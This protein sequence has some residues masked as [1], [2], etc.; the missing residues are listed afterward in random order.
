MGVQIIYCQHHSSNATPGNNF[1]ISCHDVQLL[2]TLGTTHK[3]SHKKLRTS[4]CPPVLC[5]SYWSMLQLCGM[6]LLNWLRRDWYWCPTFV[7]VSWTHRFDLA[8]L[9]ALVAPYLSLC[10]VSGVTAPFHMLILAVSCKMVSSRAFIA[11]NVTAGQHTRW[12]LAWV[13][14]WFCLHTAKCKNSSISNNSV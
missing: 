3:S 12:G 1:T 11:C 10:S 7:S 5:V 2:I 9:L 14:V 8:N 4:S 13:L 6:S